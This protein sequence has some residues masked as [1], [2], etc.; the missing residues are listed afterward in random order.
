MTPQAVSLQSKL[1]KTS[2]LSSVV[3]GLAAFILLIAHSAY[4]TM[5]V[6]DEIMDEI[7]DMLMISDLSISS[8]SQIDELSDEFDIQYQLSNQNMLL[9]QSTQFDLNTQNPRI[10]AQQDAYSFIWSGDRLLR[11]Y[12][13]FDHQ[14]KLNVHVIQP[15]SIRFKDLKHSF[16]SYL[17]ILLGLWSVQW[18]ISHFLIQKQFKPIQQLSKDIAEKS[19]NDLSLIDQPRPELKELQPMVNQL[20]Q[21]L[22]RLDQALV[23][24]Q[25]F[26]ADASHELRSPLSAIQL[27]L[28]LLQRKYAEIPELKAQLQLIQNDVNRGTQVLENLLLLARLDPM[29]E[30]QLPRAWVSVET[31]TQDVL[32]AL[33]PLINEKKIQIHIDREASDIYANAELIFICI[34]NLIDNAIRYTPALGYIYIRF[35][36][37]NNQIFYEIENDGQGIS[38]EVLDRLGERFYR[39]L[40]TQTQGSG[41]GLS[42]C[43]KIIA[44]HQGRIEFSS[45]EYGGLNVSVYL[46]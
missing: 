19:A 43:K 13:V 21:M 24:E 41:L 5:Q 32:K 6:Q 30:T 3:A 37:L 20:N 23:A 29:D 8:G 40:G 42:I 27:R 11:S 9:T 33:E 17:L 31:L 12:R 39:A 7:A 10:F 4:Q 36:H 22:T 35:G 28:Q 16:L 46:R 1:I 45:S 26:T 38:Q 18:L 2:M 34:R 15:L 44:L 14:T 25:R